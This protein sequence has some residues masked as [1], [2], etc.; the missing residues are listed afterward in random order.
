MNFYA[1]HRR[2]DTYGDDAE[3]FH[4]ER[5]ESLSLGHWD[6]LPFGG[7]PRT[8]PARQMAL[9]QAHFISL[10]QTFK[11]IATREPVFEAPEEYNI[12][13]ESKNGA[14]VALIPAL[15]AWSRSYS[16]TR[17]KLL[18]LDRICEGTSDEMR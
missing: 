5:W 2:P 12:S 13:T 15:T 9:A 14:K 16:G 1:L 7:G 8:R 10:L 18:S 3:F 6:C 17:K 4:L 11:G